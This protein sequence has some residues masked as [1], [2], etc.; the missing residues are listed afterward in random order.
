[1]FRECKER[2]SME[3]EKEGSCCTSLLKLATLPLTSG[4]PNDVIP[5]AANSSMMPRSPTTYA[6]RG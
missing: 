1:M 2:S 6:C 3:A 4:P 5:T